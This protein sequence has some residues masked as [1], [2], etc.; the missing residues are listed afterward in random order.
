MDVNGDIA[1]IDPFSHKKVSVPNSTQSIH[2]E[3]LLRS[4]RPSG[5][6]GA[7]TPFQGHGIEVQVSTVHAVKGETQAATLYMETYY[8]R[9]GGGNYESE[10]L[11]NQLK[12][13]PARSERA[14]PRKA[15]RQDGLRWIFQADTSPLLRGARES[16]CRPRGRDRRLS[17]GCGQA[18]R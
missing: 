11:A 5:A 10:R 8:E 3:R 13:G 9:G 18:R 14:R 15:V 17:L 4:E 2:R 12:G 16:V 1:L 7:P 6:R